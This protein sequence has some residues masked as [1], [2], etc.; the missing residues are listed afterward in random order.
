MSR[1]GLPNGIVDRTPVEIMA[2]LYI[3]RDEGPVESC[4]SP[5]AKGAEEAFIAFREQIAGV[6]D[7][8]GYDGEKAQQISSCHAAGVMNTWRDT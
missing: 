6:F 2:I 5:A 7:E 3:I 8:H 1:A 4:I